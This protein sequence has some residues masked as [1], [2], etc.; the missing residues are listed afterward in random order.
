VFD[1]G[2]VVYGVQHHFQQYFSYIT[3]VSFIGGENR[4]IRK[5]PVTSN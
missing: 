1:G 3:A 4:S 5:S 2:L